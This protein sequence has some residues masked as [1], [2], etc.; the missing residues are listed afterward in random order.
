MLQKAF[1]VLLISLITS[2]VFASRGDQQ[3]PPASSSRQTLAQ[4]VFDR[5]VNA[6]GGR[7]AYAKITSRSVKGKFE[8]NGSSQTTPGSFEP[9]HAV[10]T[11]E[12]YWKAPNKVA[13][14]LLGPPLAVKRGYNGKDAWGFH[15]QAGVRKIS[16]VE[17]AEIVRDGTLYQP[18]ALSNHY[19]QMSYDGKRRVDGP[20][21]DIIEATTKDNRIERFYFDSSTGL[22]VRLDLWE[23]GPEAVR[24]QGEYYLAQY[25][26]G[27][28]RIV[29]GIQVP[30]SI[31]RVRPHS[32]MIFTFTEVKQNI[33]LDDSIFEAP[34]QSSK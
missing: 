31:R 14:V 16:P 25:Y 21:V 26:L 28:Y 10:G 3:I 5:Y 27:D 33:A 19:T 30:F 1:L 12:M 24:I 6:L 13:A 20:E 4:Q 29:N 18:L 32:T 34:R 15:P 2:C 23:E 17:I 22:P 9:Q 8:Y 11:V 7:D